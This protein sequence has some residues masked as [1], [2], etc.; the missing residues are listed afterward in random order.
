MH[1]DRAERHLPHYTAPN[2]SVH[3]EPVST[4]SRTLLAVPRDEPAWLAPREDIVAHTWTDRD[5]SWLE[6]NRRVLH[7]AQD[8]RT[9][10][11]ERAKFLAIFSSNLDEF[12]MKRMGVL[13]G[14]AAAEDES[15]PG[16][17]GGDAREHLAALRNTVLRMLEAQA[18]CYIG[19]IV[20]ELRRNGIVLA[21]W[22]E[23]TEA[24]VAEAAAHFDQNV[25]PALTPLGFDSAHPFPFISNLSTNWAFV[26]R[27]PGSDEHMQVRVKSPSGLAQYFALKSDVPAGERWF[28]AI[29]DVIRYNAGKLFPGMEIVSATLF[30]IIRNAEVDLDED[31]VSTLP[32]AVR[33]AVRERRFQPVVR[34]DFA[35]GAT[36]EIRRAL[37]ERFELTDADVYEV[38]GLVDYTDLFQ[39]ANLDV[40]ALRDPPWEPLPAPRVAEHVR[41]FEAIQAG[42]V[43]VHHPYDSFED[44]VERF[45]EEASADPETLAIKMTVYRVGDD[46]P[47]VRSLI[48]AAEAGKQVACIV[49]VKARFDEERNLHWAAELQKVGAHVVYGVLG[50]KTHTKL[51]LVVRRE[52]GGLRCYAH[53]GTGN[54]HVRTARTYTD[55]G[56][57][58]CDPDVTADV[59]NLFHFFTGRSIAPA[60]RRLLIAPHTMRERFLQLIEREIEHQRAGRQGRIIAK[61]NQVEDLMICRA[62]VAASRAGVSIDLVVRGFCCLLPGVPGW[63]DNIRVRSIVGRFLEHSRIFYFANGAVEPLQG[64]FYIGSADW[65]YRNLSLR[66][67]AAVPIAAPALRAR[68]WEILDSA[69]RDRRQAWEMDSEGRYVQCEPTQPAGPEGIGSQAWLLDLARHR[70]VAR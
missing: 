67:E 55:V 65:M 40:P 58:T 42:D 9:P 18:Q 23:L 19:D 48:A 68:L 56:L 29:E 49:E 3:P 21:Q 7:E 11:L 53:I 28:I 10:L 8:P 36:P 60:F 16:I 69:L 12:F 24:Q 30:R 38:R 5:R 43:L 34:V 44:S 2:A 1:K 63:T 57:F 41:I 61:M 66:V 15:D 45:I 64:D 52:A 54:Y 46:T 33:D 14:K 70:M 39:I 32:Q 51:A 13:R 25:S 20:P 17:F 62:L 4:L 59:V 50:L 47:F 27:T 26:L 37:M 22:S 35:P 31:E 6:F